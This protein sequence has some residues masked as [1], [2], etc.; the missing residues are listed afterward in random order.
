ML[1]A[2]TVQSCTAIMWDGY[3]RITKLVNGLRKFMERKGYNSIEDF[4]GIALPHI[5]PIQEYAAYPRK[6]VVLEREKCNNCGLCLNVCYYDAL[7]SDSQEQLQTRPENCDGCGL[8]VEFCPH[9]ALSL[10]E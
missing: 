5:M 6:R 3:E 4:R 9:D 7:Y 10:R 1:G 8:C 2:T